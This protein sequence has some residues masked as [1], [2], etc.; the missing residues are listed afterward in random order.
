M[1]VTV[2]PIVIDWLG[3]VNKK[4]GIGTRGFENERTS[5]HPPNYSIVGIG[6]NTE[7]S[8][9]DLKRLGVTVNR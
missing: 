5:R 6:H 4:I 3:T 1:N 9:V 8:P 7:K 2:I